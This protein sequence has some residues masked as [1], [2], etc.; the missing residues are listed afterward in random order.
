[1]NDAIE[2]KRLILTPTPQNSLSVL[3]GESG[4]GKS[5]SVCKYAR[6]LREQGEPVY[7]VSLIK[8]DKPMTRDTFLMNLF[9]TED[10]QKIYDVLE[11][12]YTVKGKTATLIIDNI[13]Y[14]QH[15]GV[16]CSSIL[17]TLNLGFFQMLK[18]NV[19]M[20]SAVND[21]AYKMNYGVVIIYFI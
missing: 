18:M 19:I 5:S 17:S 11:K 3:I 16:L 2:I 4:I 10:F 6:I 7:Y 14:L 15:N 12:N 8:Q 1:M 13:H 20:L 9:G 21:F